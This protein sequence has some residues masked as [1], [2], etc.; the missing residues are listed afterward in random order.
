MQSSFETNAKYNTIRDAQRGGRVDLMPFA[1]RPVL[2]PIEEYVD[3]PESPGSD[4]TR[5]Q[6]LGSRRS[7]VNG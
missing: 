2:P 1:D 6:S 4:S 7:H 5:N 3:S